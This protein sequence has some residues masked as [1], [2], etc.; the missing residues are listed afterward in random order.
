MVDYSKVLLSDTL[1]DILGMS[2][3]P[4]ESII[5]D[6]EYVMRAGVELFLK[7][8]INSE[9]AQ[10][11]KSAIKDL[12]NGRLMFSDAKL[13]QLVDNYVLDYPQLVSIKHKLIRCSTEEELISMIN[14]YLEMYNGWLSYLEKERSRHGI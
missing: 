10:I 13:L 11:I 14:S 3:V 9:R 5:N 2:S 6:K 4:K 8:E 12:K 7:G 1:K